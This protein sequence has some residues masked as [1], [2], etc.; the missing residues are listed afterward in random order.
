MRKHLQFVLVLVAVLMV[1]SLP[2]LAKK[3]SDLTFEQWLEKYGAW[4]QLEKEYAQEADKDTPQ[5]ILKRAEVYLNLNSPEKALEIL[6]MTP[7]FAEDKLEAERLWMGGQAQRA[8]GNL[9]KS[10]LWFSQAASHISN[11]KE[12][13]KRYRSEPDLEV[14][15]Q[16]VWLKLYWSYLANYTLS[17]DT[18][19]DALNRISELGQQIWGGEYWTEVDY[20]LHPENRPAPE[21]K[22]KSKKEELEP[23]VPAEPYVSERDFELIIKALA[24]TSLEKFDDATAL[25]SSINKPALRFFWLS[26]L[27]Y[28]E[29]GDQPDSLSPLI[30][31]N[32]LKATAFWQGNILGSYP[33]SR[34]AW[35]LG[36][37]DSGP[38]T[39]FRNNLLAMSPDEASQAIE[40]ELQSMLISDQ[41]A[42]LLN[43][44]KLALTLSSGN[45]EIARKSWNSLEKQ[46]LPITLQLAG[47]L[48]FKEDLKNVLP[49]KP[50]ESFAV[51][52]V[53]ATLSGAAGQDLNI[54]TEAPFWLAAPQAKVQ[55]ISQTQY[56]M[57]K[58]LLLSYWQQVFD[59]E[60]TSELAKRSAFL[61]DDTVLGADAL[62]HLADEAVKA[63]KLQLGAFYLNGVNAASL[64]PELRMEWLDIKT[65]LEL[66]SGRNGTAL[67]TYKEMTETGLDIPVMTRL[68]MALLYQQRREFEAAKEQ[69]LAMWEKK[70]TMTTTLQAE[71]LF[72]LGEGEQGMRHPEAALDYYLK[73]AWEYPQE[74]IWALTAMY[75]ASLLY[76]KRGKYETAK[77]L[78]GTVVKRADT[79]EQRE[80]A[81]ARIDA[82]D[83]KMG[84]SR[85][86]KTE[87][88]LVYPF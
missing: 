42:E 4:D 84:K 11:E 22:K 66:D 18:Q 80:A 62:L 88:I 71:T 69:L 67:N 23:V 21:P 1:T 39:K 82:I 86:K 74:N 53:F 16:D 48:L 7:A 30:D 27:G 63:K 57:D 45:H 40:V 49:V 76:E 34:N 70:S 51:Y 10:V 79:K 12:L 6:E 52:P 72:W 44:F 56:P 37:P 9:S 5:V 83:K 87:S 13:K 43:N 65:R 19:L 17:K 75:R 46:K 25:L 78:L 31:G 60:A 8:T 81:K 36:N 58:L 2:A 29:S 68:R 55:E 35:V 41:T 64:S 73:L 14:I 54:A 15:W 50:A 85:K 26:V 20:T 59:R 28:F 38:W 47:M 24:S 32:Y 77:K 33:V 61:F 3:T